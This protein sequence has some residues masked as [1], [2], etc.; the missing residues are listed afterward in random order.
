MT[1]L[2]YL[3]MCLAEEAAEIIKPAMKGGRFGLDNYLPGEPE[4]TNAMSIAN[5]LNDV[6][7][8]ILMINN[9]RVIDSTNSFDPIL[10]DNMKHPKYGV[11]TLSNVL[12]LIYNRFLN[13]E[14]DVYQEAFKAGRLSIKGYTEDDGRL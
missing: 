1:R 7:A 6:L 5:E 3:L 8:V 4:L 14:R 10:I 9:E 13:R 11:F 12:Q 2:E